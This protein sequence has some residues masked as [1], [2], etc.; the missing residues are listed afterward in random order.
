MEGAL[1]STPISG[2]RTRQGSRARRRQL[3]AHKPGQGEVCSKPLLGCQHLHSGCPPVPHHYRRQ[4]STRHLAPSCCTWNAVAG[5]TSVPESHM[6]PHTTPAEHRSSA[7]RRLT[8]KGKREGKGAGGMLALG[9]A[10]SSNTLAKRPSIFLRGIWCPAVNST[11]QKGT[12]CSFPG[13]QQSAAC[14]TRP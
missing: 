8:K 9:A 4:C 2:R 13:Q 10:W 5:G 3:S 11:Q 14:H 7:L 1:P 6:G 12:C